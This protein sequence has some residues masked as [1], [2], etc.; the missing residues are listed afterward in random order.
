LPRRNISNFIPFWFKFFC[1]NHHPNVTYTFGDKI[2]FQAT[3]QSDVPISN[4]FI[5]FQA[6]NDA[7]RTGQ[8]NIDSKGNLTFAFDARQQAIR[9][10]ARIYYWFH[11]TLTNGEEFSSPSFCLTI[12]IT[13]LSGQNVEDAVFRV[14]WYQGDLALG[15]NAFKRC[16]FRP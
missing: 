6:E 12:S 5:F 8:V 14:R 13:G 10:F 7:T 2:I 15:Q 4:T 3:I 9:P 16:P 1:T 11:G